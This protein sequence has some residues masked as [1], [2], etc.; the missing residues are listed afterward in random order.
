MNLVYNLL[1]TGL[2]FPSGELQA[3]L[4]S[5]TRDKMIIFFIKVVILFALCYVIRVIKK[6]TFT[7]SQKP[8]GGL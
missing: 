8:F 1:H 3:I 4:F 7:A 2:Q 5:Y 6:G